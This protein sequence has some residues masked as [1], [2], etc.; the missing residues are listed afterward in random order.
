MSYHIPYIV[1]WQVNTHYNVLLPKIVSNEQGKDENRG[2]LSIIDEKTCNAS[3]LSTRLTD[4][5]TILQDHPSDLCLEMSIMTLGAK[6]KNDN[7]SRNERLLTMM[8]S[9]ASPNLQ[10]S[11]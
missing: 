4:P 10:A 8:A 1:V 9:L 2:S 5:E 3:L 7:E 6:A 11:E